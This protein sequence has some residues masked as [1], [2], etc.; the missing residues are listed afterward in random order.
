MATSPKGGLGSEGGYDLSSYHQ[1][2]ESIQENELTPIVERHTMLVQ[3]SEG[4][5]PT[6]NFEVQWKPVDTPTAK[7]QSEINKNKADTDKTL[8]DAGAIQPIDS[9]KRLIRDPD[10]GYDG[11]EEEYEGGDR[12]EGGNPNGGGEDPHETEVSTNE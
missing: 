6:V 10:S 11:I 3:L 8:V 9:R 12:D 7:E 5:V 2:L 1:F 4:I